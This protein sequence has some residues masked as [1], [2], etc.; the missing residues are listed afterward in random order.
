MTR[1]RLPILIAILALFVA[2][3]LPGCLHGDGTNALAGGESDDDYSPDDDAADDDLGDDTQDDDSADD[4]TEDPIHLDIPAGCNPFAT[5]Q[6][7]HLPYP[8]A[9]YQV[10]DATRPTGVRVD[11]PDDTIP[12]GEGVVPFDMDPINAADGTSPAGPILVHFGRDVDPT[13]LTTIHELPESLAEGN[14]IALFDLEDDARVLFLSEMDLNRRDDYPG[15]YALIV[16]PLAP[17]AMGHRHVVALTKDVTDDAGAPFDSPPAFAALRDGVP[18]DN[19]QVEG[20][21]EHYEEL[22]DFL[23]ARGYPRED[24]L[25]AW[26]FM[27]A[28]DDYLLGSVVSMRDQAIAEAHGTGL[29]Y[30]ITAVYDDPDEYLTRIVEGT[31]EVTTYLRED[32]SFAYD[33]DH[34][35]VRQGANLSFPFTMIIPKKA[36]TLGEPL[37]LVLFGHG[38][39]GNGR[40]Y[41][42]GWANGI[43][44]SMAEA[45]GA[46]LIATDW[47][48]LSEGDLQIILQ[49]VIP[50]LNRITVVTDRLQQSLVNNVVL[51][52]LALGDLS[53]DAVV[54]DGDHELIDPARVYYYG[55]SLGGIQG[56]SFVS[57]SDRITRG[58]LAVPGSAW[59]DMFTRS[60]NWLP[61]KLVMDMDY[62]DPL[63]QQFAIA[64]V[65]TLFDQ[66]DPVNLTRMML[67]DPLPDAPERVVFL[68]ESIGDSQ[69]PNMTTE[70]LARAIGVKRLTPAN[71]DVF[72]LEP[73]TSPTTDSVLAQ[74]YLVDQV[75]ADPPPEGNVPPTS[76][77]GAHADMVFLP[78]VQAQVLHF[79]ETGEVVQYCNGPCDPD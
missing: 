76:D 25:L 48:G 43:T 9:F 45:G 39:F 53:H 11:Y 15:R 65:Q 32:N 36:V 51:T 37:P 13:R 22:F 1:T 49:E 67:R 33:A 57:I 70:L 78:H 68:Q 55:V 61:I 2:A 47:I 7:C 44:H 27:V 21:R 10:P 79:I 59:M 41:L 74:Y 52:E 58:V 40:Q 60:V 19:D 56:S 8:S 31:F 62:P 77:N 4:D 35:P 34:H 14:P 23:E 38:L 50:D 3:L 6:E 69:V 72:G 5:S 18:T 66:S 54:W 17:M 29:G 73:V 16:R 30:A 75:E 24:L 64:F 63:V 42:N 71:T 46:V 20:V 12:V 26:D 28:S